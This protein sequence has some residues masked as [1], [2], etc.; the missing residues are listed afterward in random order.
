MELDIDGNGSLDYGE[1]CRSELVK[2]MQSMSNE[3]DLRSLFDKIDTDKS[4]TIEYAEFIQVPINH[5]I[6]LSQSNL[7]TAF[8]AL[9]NDTGVVTEAQIEIFLSSTR[10][11]EESEGG[12]VD[13]IW[14]DIPRPRDIDIDGDGQIT[15]E[16]F[17]DAMF[18]VAQHKIRDKLIEGQYEIF[19]KSVVKR[20]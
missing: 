8:N 7:E 6:Q 2:D 14:N 11:K 10:S 9:T 15:R 13:P 12:E 4:G 1:F 17:M 20:K 3:Q 5:C 19:S 18:K 16:E